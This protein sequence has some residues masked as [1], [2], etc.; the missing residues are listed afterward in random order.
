MT[1]GLSITG[2]SD[3][4]QIDTDKSYSYYGVVASGTGTS[5]NVSGLNSNKD[6]I[7]G[8]PSGGTGDLAIT[9][10]GTTI[11]FYQSANYYVLRPVLDVGDSGS[12]YGLRVYNQDANLAFDSGYFGASQDVILQVA[13]TVDAGL[14]V[15][16]PSSSSSIIYTDTDYQS[17]YANL[18]YGNYI[19]TTTF[20]NGFSWLSASTSVR[21]RSFVL[22]LGTYY[23]FRNPAV[24]LAKVAI[25]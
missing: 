4:L 8:K 14:L 23:Y 12:G 21:F 11:T 2:S 3:N 6:L 10:S 20:I 7:F 18:N 9:I 25:P 5:V 17:V 1:Y 15:G 16:N 13:T 22:V 19:S 24:I